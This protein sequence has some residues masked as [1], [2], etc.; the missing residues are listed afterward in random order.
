[1]TEP[2]AD[3]CPRCGESAILSGSAGS[4]CANDH[5]WAIQPDDPINHPPHYTA[6]EI[7]CI[8]ALKSALTFDEFRGFCKGSVIQYLWR[9][10]H[11][12]VLDDARKAAWYCQR[13]VEELGA[14]KNPRGGGVKG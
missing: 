1:M 12:G 2:T 4:I 9:E 7:E 8:T 10:R 6:G 3:T 5:H 13:L 11:K 14:E